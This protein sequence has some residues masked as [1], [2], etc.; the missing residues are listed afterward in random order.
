MDKG[1]KNQ[2]EK[3]ELKMGEKRKRETGGKKMGI[4]R[5]KKREKKT[6]GKQVDPQ[7]GGSQG[8][9]NSAEEG[10]KKDIRLKIESQVMA[11]LKEQKEKMRGLCK[12]KLE[13]L[14]Q[15]KN[16]AVERGKKLCTILEAKVAEKTK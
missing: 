11:K 16:K 2:W 13:Q 8:S 10:K 9:K 3:N 7:T 15:A 5:S 1:G 4:I 12:Y 14:F 6:Q